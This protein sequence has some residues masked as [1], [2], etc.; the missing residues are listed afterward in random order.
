MDWV[1]VQDESSGE[2]IWKRNYNVLDHRILKFPE[3]ARLSNSSIVST[4][5]VG[6][7]SRIVTTP[8][9]PEGRM[10]FV[11]AEGASA[12]D[13]EPVSPL[14]KL[15]Y[16]AVSKLS[17][18]QKQAWFVQHTAAM[19]VPWEFGHMN[20]EIDRSNLLHNSCEQLLWAN[21]AQLHQSL[22]IKFAGEPGV[23]A[24]TFQNYLRV[25]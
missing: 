13:G 19:E 24:G 14:Q 6:Y 1:R 23:D 5:S 10:S 18:L 22:R 11:E 12:S 9:H 8:K 25:H 3:E 16:Q 21:P 20:L 17:F 2:L 7:I 15:E 4:Q